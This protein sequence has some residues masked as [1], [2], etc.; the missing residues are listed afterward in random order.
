MFMI[1]FG[2]SAPGRMGKDFEPTNLSQQDLA[3]KRGCAA[4]VDPQASRAV[5]LYP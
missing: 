2:P 3:P 4:D 1:C 5:A